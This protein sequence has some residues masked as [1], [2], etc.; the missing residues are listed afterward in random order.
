MNLKGILTKVANAL[1]AKHDDAI[2]R[3]DAI[4]DEKARAHWNGRRAAYNKAALLVAK[5]LMELPDTPSGTRPVPSLGEIRRRLPEGYS[6][7]KVEDGCREFRY[8]DGLLVTVPAELRE[9]WPWI[10]LRLKN[11]GETLSEAEAAEVEALCVRADGKR[12]VLTTDKA[13]VFLCGVKDDGGTV[14]SLYG[15]DGLVGFSNSYREGLWKAIELCREIG[16]D[17]DQLEHP[18]VK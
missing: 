7:G 6:L 11:A 15:P 8:P 12:R 1:H 3:R 16:I 14:Y 17:P 9:A 10:L 18:C 5:E 13:E 2:Q 4:T